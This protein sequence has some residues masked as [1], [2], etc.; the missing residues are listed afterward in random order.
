MCGDSWA[1]GIFMRINCKILKS[2]I[3]KS[4]WRIKCSVWKTGHVIEW[5]KIHAEKLS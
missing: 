4:F 5:K 2:E 1:K 3:L